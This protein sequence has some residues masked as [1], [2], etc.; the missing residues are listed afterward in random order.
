MH[1]WLMIAGSGFL[2]TLALLLPEQAT[3]LAKVAFVWALVVI[4]AFR[5]QGRMEYQSA[6]R[7]MRQGEYQRAIALMTALID[8]EPDVLD[9][10]QFR[11]QLYR[12]SGDL[13]RAAADYEWMR[14]HVLGFIIG[15]IGLAEIEMYQGNYDRAREYALA[16]R[17]RDRGWMAAYALGLIEDRQGHAELAVE[18]LKAA[19]T[20]SIPHSRFRLLARLWLARNYHRLGCDDDAGKQIML[21]RKEKKG[22]R[23]WQV[24]LESDQSALLR[25]LLEHDLQ[26][27]QQFVESEATL[28][29]LD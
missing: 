21:L 19:L 8:T 5:S 17:E 27:A 16:A 15:A 24:I 28:E 22:L 4:L 7:L 29:A 18:H 14:G 9:H 10:R 2:L 1:I 26:L 13:Q 23:E 12:L 11:A 6:V 3:F 20:S 25:D